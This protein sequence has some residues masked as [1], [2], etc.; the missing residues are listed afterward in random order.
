MPKYTV[1]VKLP[2]PGQT[3]KVTRRITIE[4]NNSMTAVLQARGQYG[5]E[6]VFGGALEIKEIKNSNNSDNK[7]SLKS[8]SYTRSSVDRK[9]SEADFKKREND[10]IKDIIDISEQ[11]YGKAEFRKLIGKDPKK[12]T[13]KEAMDF[14]RREVNK[15]SV[16]GK[17][18]NFIDDDEKYRKEK[19]IV[20]WLTK[21]VRK[22]GNFVKDKLKKK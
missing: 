12:L 18:K 9:E 13:Y 11:K 17:I 16:L 8:T 3:Q 1:M 22:I 7:S 19:G 20:D 21:D 2:W 5:S 14:N 15:G 10:L 4:A 6:N